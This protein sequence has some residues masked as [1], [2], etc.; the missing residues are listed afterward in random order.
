MHGKYLKLLIFNETP[1]TNINEALFL[2]STKKA[3]SQNAQG[4]FEPQLG[5]YHKLSQHG[6]SERGGIFV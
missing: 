2:L 5:E 1:W 3:R 4:M 6:C